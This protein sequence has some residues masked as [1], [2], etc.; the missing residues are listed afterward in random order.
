MLEQT[1]GRSSVQLKYV[2]RTSDEMVE[3]V[4]KRF[5]FASKCVPMKDNFYYHLLVRG[6]RSTSSPTPDYLLPPFLTETG[7]SKL[8]VRLKVR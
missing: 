5:C 8:K 7:F 2:T 4:W 1:S 3:L 6:E